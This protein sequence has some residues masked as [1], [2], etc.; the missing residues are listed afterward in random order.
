MEI[1][2]NSTA[3]HWLY[4]Q[5]GIYQIFCSIFKFSIFWGAYFYV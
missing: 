1:I 4:G 5:S 2:L 3:Y